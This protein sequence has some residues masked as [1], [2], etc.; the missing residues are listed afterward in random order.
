MNNRVRVAV[1]LACLGLAAPLA[2]Q[3]ITEFPIPTAS[4]LPY[5]VSRPARTATCGSPKSANKIGRITTAGVITEFPIPTPASG[6]VGIAA[7]PDGNLWFTETNAN[8][9]GRITTAGVITEFPIPTASSY[10]TAS[11]PARTATCGSPKL[12][13]PDRPD[14]DGRRHHRV[15]DSHGRTAGP[16]GI[17][18]G[19]DGN[20]WFTEGNGNQIGR[21]TTAGVITEFP[22]PTA[23]SDP[24][25]IAAG[26]DGN[27]WF[28]EAY[29]QPD[30]PDHH[31]RRHHRVPAS[32]RPAAT[33]S[34]SRPARTA[35]SGSPSSSQQDRPDHDG[36]RHHRVFRSRRPAAAPSGIA[37]GPD[38]NLWFT[39][40]TPTTS[41]GLRRAAPAPPTR[42]RCA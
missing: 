31:G 28:T 5:G 23:N 33:R 38:G 9:I 27:L 35:T 15:P 22:I 32:Q 29:W 36:R 34:A 39:E 4:Q 2:A 42:R 20:L 30:R 41:A 14:H 6:P 25:G 26:P 11:R 40:V 18:A 24:Y 37:A 17:A 13:Q 19:P 1:A 21:I 12:G 10:P 16:G 3:T 7:G 8:K